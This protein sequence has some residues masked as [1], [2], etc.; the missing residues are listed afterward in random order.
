MKIRILPLGAFEANCVLVSD[1][2]G[3]TL[4]TDPGA[5]ADDVDSELTRHG[6][7]V[8][9]Y[10]L[11]HG[12]VDHVSALTDLWRRRQAPVLIHPADAAW[13][14][15]PANAIPPYPAPARPAGPY[16]EVADNSVFTFGGLTFRV[17]STPGHTPGCVCFYFEKEGVL[18]TGDTLFEGS[19]GRT[20]LPGGNG[21]T[22]ADSLLK[23]AVLP[24]AVRVIAGHGE[25]TTIGNELQNNYFMQG[26]ARA[27]ARL[28]N[29]SGL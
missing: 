23:L 24:P 22:L 6:L 2:E 14:F 11:T 15:T 8:G 7:K 21:R 5:D 1:D 13:A 3:L 12:H 18:L 20:D 17:L 26:A 27:L 10:L 19:V 29:K 9:A 4:V 28:K 25:E 16:P